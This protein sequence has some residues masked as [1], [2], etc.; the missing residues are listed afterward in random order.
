MSDFADIRLEST[1]VP[2]PDLNTLFKYFS[3]DLEI[4]AINHFS[5]ENEDEVQS[6]EVDNLN[7]DLVINV[8]ELHHKHFP[9]VPWQLPRRQQ[10]E[11]VARHERQ[12]HHSAKKFAETIQ[13]VNVELVETFNWLLGLMVTH[14]N[15][16]RG[17]RGGRWDQ[18]QRRASVNPLEKPGP[19]GQRRPEPWL[20]SKNTG[21][22]ETIYDLIYVNSD[23]N[24]D[25]LRRS[26]ETW[27]APNQKRVPTAYV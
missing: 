27:K 13:L 19:D 10:A 14:I 22:R 1:R 26:D 16:I 24:L 5:I 7:F 4:S 12:P 15:M 8:F 23:N 20:R 11:I 18:S 6:G 3:D 9:S 25:N 17:V 21:T 2:I